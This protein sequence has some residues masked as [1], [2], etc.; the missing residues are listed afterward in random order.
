MSISREPSR[1]NG[2]NSLSVI[3]VFINKQRPHTFI[4]GQFCSN[5]SLI[6]HSPEETM[7]S[8]RMKI[9]YD[10]GANNGDDIPYYLM[11]A[12]LVVAVEANP[13]LCH[14]IKER[15]Q[16]EIDNGNLIIESCVLTSDDNSS[17]VCFYIHKKYHVLSQF[18][19][20]PLLSLAEYEEIL[21]PSKSV[22]SIIQHHGFPH[23]IKLDIEHYDAE[24]LKTL[25]RNNIFPPYISA[26][27]HDID[28]F[29]CLVSEGG[30]NAFKLVDG[31]SVPKIYSDRLIYR[32]KEQDEVRYSF[33]THS[34]GPFGGDVDGPWMSANSFFRLLA[35]EGLGWK[36]IHATNQ[37]PFD[38]STYFSPRE[39]VNKYLKK[40]L[41]LKL[42]NFL[43]LG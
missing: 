15:F 41:V 36:D 4:V 12:D 20:P 11:K 13:V 10:F 33:K 7:V 30:Y 22:T 19:K 17:Y 18:I 40:K 5:I 38:P 35:F 2:S 34:A 37:E 26:E 6:L 8:S 21:L 9:I 25:F 43:S 24:I 42:K 32:E 23:Y 16:L 39:Y 29:S 3:A 31:C 14:L 27:S 28:V 1:T